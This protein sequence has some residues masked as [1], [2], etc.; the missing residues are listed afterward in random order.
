MICFVFSAK[1]LII[2]LQGRKRCSYLLLRIVE[3]R[4]VLQ[5]VLVGHDEILTVD[6]L[7]GDRVVFLEPMGD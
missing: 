4:D 1:T 7:A 5:K 6:H 2:M 3:V